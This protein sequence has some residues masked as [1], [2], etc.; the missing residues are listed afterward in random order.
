PRHLH[1]FPT[2]RSSDLLSLD[3]VRN[4]QPIGVV[5]QVPTDSPSQNAL[6]FLLQAPFYFELV[7]PLSLRQL[8]V[9]S[10]DSN[11]TP[12]TVRP[13]V[14]GDRK[15]TRLNSSHVKI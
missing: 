9:E 6:G 4:L 10:D 11:P 7:Q 3:L 14:E 5:R 15:S 12:Q 13:F 8:L 1:S 2:R